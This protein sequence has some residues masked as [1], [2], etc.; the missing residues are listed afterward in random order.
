MPLWSWSATGL[1]GLKK[2]WTLVTGGSKN[3]GAAL[4]LALAKQGRA[5]A[6]HY[7]HSA[8]EAFE[9]VD[10]CRAMGSQAEAIQGDFNSVSSVKDFIERYLRQFSETDTLINNVGDYLIGSALNTSTEDWM[11]LFQVN[12]HTPFMLMQ[13]LSP[14]LIRNKGNMINIGASG[15]HRHAA[16]TYS[17]AYSLTKQGLWA[18]TLSLARELASRDVRVN[19]V[20]PGQLNLSIDQP[21]IP[22]NRPVTCHEVCRV[23]NFLLDPDSAMITGQNIEVAGGLGLA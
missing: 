8:Q 17:T 15:L 7:H 20:S 22:M 18:L 3:L 2:M 6:I 4:C 16:H 1:K 11:H 14:S 12:L 21:K 9:I 5:I 19:M 23:V 10:Q 13:A